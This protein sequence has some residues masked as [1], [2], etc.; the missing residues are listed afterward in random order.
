MMP[1]TRCCI[2]AVLV[3]V[4]PFVAGIIL[5][6][7]GMWAVGLPVETLGTGLILALQKPTFVNVVGCLLLPRWAER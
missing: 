1:S 3:G 5:L 6:D 7:Y 4:I 2:A